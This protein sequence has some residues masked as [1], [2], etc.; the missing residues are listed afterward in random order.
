MV[1]EGLCPCVLL[2]FLPLSSSRTTSVIGYWFHAGADTN[3]GPPAA[4]NNP[5][6]RVQ[7]E[8]QGGLHP[9]RDLQTNSRSLD[10][11]DTQRGHGGSSSGWRRGTL[12]YSY[13][14]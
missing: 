13:K 9:L 7:E 11:G 2:V 12:R 6:G 5:G 8:T 4:T 3:Q 1:Q 10:I 14:E